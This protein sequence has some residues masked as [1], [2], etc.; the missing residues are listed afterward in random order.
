[1]LLCPEKYSLYNSFMNLLGE[2]A[3]EARGFDVQGKLNA[4]NLRINAQMYRFP[5]R[6]RNS[7][8]RHILGKANDILL[9]EIRKYNPDFVLV[10]NSEFLLP[11][12]CAMI[13]ANARLVFFMGDSP[14]Y[15]P[16]N[17]YYL[18][19]LPHADLILSSDSFWNEQLNTMGLKQ[20]LFFVPGIDQR[21]YFPFNEPGELE[22]IEA[23]D[24]LYVGT[25][26]VNS[27]GYKKA[28]LMSQ[29]TEFNFR[30]YGNLMWKRWFSFFPELEEKFIVSGFIPLPVLNKMFNR[31]K[32]IPVDGNPGILNGFHMRLVEA[33]GAGALPIVEYRKDIADKL[34]K[35]SIVM[36]PQITDYLKAGDLANYFLINDAERTELIREL[37]GFLLKKYNIRNNSELLLERLI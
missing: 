13:K 30:L 16:L 10:Y 14:F 26:Y 6:I 24:V 19:C 3:Q 36:V 20:T 37:N 28:L 4:A 22:G 21:S 5:F 33:L 11:E 9:A 2:M 25:C 31:A 17:N 1:M 35:G 29:F 12:T 8:E 18:A 7:W 27:W 34:F 15:T 23:R 32:L